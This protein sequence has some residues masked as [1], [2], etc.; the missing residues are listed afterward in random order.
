[1]NDPA[2]NV[3]SPMVKESSAA[4]IFTSFRRNRSCASALSALWL[5]T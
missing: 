2:L 4:E 1:M 5:M 3:R